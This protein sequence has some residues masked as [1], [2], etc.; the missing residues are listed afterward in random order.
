MEA[1]SCSSDSP[2]SLETSI[3]FRCSPKRQKKKK[4]EKK[5]ILYRDYLVPSAI[6]VD[7]WMCT[8]AY[9]IIYKTVLTVACCGVL[10]FLFPFFLIVAKYT[11]QWP[12]QPFFSVWFGSIKCIHIVQP[13]QHPSLQ[14]FSI[15]IYFIKISA[16]EFPS[17]LSGNEPDWYPWRRKFDPWPRSG[18]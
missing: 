1:G 16:G 9:L 6:Y 3:C 15:S 14:N 2:P 4:K 8:R 18:G 5:H 10:S 7:V 11:F 12:F 13:S 17:W